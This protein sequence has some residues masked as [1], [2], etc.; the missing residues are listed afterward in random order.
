[1]LGAANRD[2]ARWSCPAE[3]HFGR[4]KL[5][6]HLA[7]GRGP[8]TCIGAPLARFEVQ[9][10]LK[11]LLAKTRRVTIDDSKHG[12]AGSRQ[13]DYEP[14]YIIRGLNQLYLVLET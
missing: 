8:H 3:V 11:E 5:I 2:P 7:F 13:F 6:E 12:V 14:S 10:M 9:I 1:M 4:E